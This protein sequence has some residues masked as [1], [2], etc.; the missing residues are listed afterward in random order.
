[1]TPNAEGPG[2]AEQPALYVAA[3]IKDTRQNVEA[4]IR[5][6]RRAGVDHFFIFHEGI[7]GGFDPDEYPYVT[8]LASRNLHPEEPHLNRR[9]RANSNLINQYLSYIGARGWLLP[10]DGDEVFHGDKS[11]LKALGSELKLVGLP[12]LESV[13]LRGQD[14]QNARLYRKLLSDRELSWCWRQGY[15]DSPSNDSWLRGHVQG[16]YLV[17]IDPDL[18]LAV[19]KVRENKGGYLEPAVLEGFYV[20]HYDSINYAEF[21]RKFKA[22]AATDAS[23]SA[24]KREIIEQFRRG[25]ARG[26]LP[27]VAYR[28]YVDQV[29]EKDVALKRGKGLLFEMPPVVNPARTI[30]FEDVLTVDEFFQKHGRKNAA[31]CP[32]T[33]KDL[34]VWKRFGRYMKKRLGR[35]VM[36][37]A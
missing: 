35:A 20:R 6:N 19:H 23:F 29:E 11:G 9:Q 24:R 31:V 37:V 7:S 16:K 34:R 5:E 10:I 17:R 25:Q 36:S 8:W 4:F 13:S 1:V 22:L 26:E 28:I 18:V 14:R 15:I 3:T 33:G 30:A 21:T 27:G 12:P 2:T 32:K